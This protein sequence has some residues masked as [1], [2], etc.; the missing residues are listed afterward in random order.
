MNLK[1]NQIQYKLFF[2]FAMNCN[3]RKNNDEYIN[4][5]RI[6]LNNYQARRFSFVDVQ[7]FFRKSEE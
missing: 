2:A 3:R 7:Q 1:G 5:T 6:Y 4:I